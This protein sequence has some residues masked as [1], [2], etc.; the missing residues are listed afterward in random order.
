MR[1][2][3][4]EKIQRL[5]DYC[6]AFNKTF[7][8]TKRSVKDI[9]NKDLVE[10]VLYLSASDGIIQQDESDFINNLIGINGTPEKWK[11]YLEENEIYGEKFRNVVPKSLKIFVTVDNIIFE[12]KNNKFNFCT[13]FI[14][15]FEDI[16]QDII[17][18]DRKIDVIELRDLNKYLNM[19]KLYVMS[20]TKRDNLNYEIIAD[21]EEIRGKY[22]EKRLKNEV[23]EAVDTY[24]EI[25]LN[26][27]DD[28]SI[29]K[30]WA[31]WTDN[32]YRVLGISVSS[33]TEEA[34][35]SLDK[36]KKLVRL[37]AVES[38][39]SDYHLIGLNKP[40]RNLSIVQN[41]FSSLSDKKYKWFWFVNV[42]ACMAW[43]NERF[44]SELN[45][46]GFK[47]GS[48]DLF[49]A[50]YLYAV[51]FNP[52]MSDASLWKTVF[53]YCAFLCNESDHSMLKSRF[54][55][56][57]LKDIRGQDIVRSFKSE[58][59]KPIEV[60]CDTCD[61]LRIVRLYKILKEVKCIDLEMFISKVLS[62]L[63]RYFISREATIN[64]LVNDC[65]EDDVITKS[66]VEKIKIAGKKYLKEVEGIIGYVLKE[67]QDEPIRRDM[68]EE[69]FRHATWSL[70]FAFHKADERDTAVFYANKCYPH[71]REEDKRKIRWTFGFSSI[72]GAEKEASSAEWDNMGDNYYRGEDGYSQNYAEAFKWYKKAAEAGNKYSMNSLG[73]C[74]LNGNGTQK[75]EYEA[76]KWFEKAYKVG[77][78]YGAFN[79][80]NCYA[81]GEGK[82]EDKDRAI[83]LFLEA[84][85]MGHPTAAE[86]ADA[87]IKLVNLEKKNHR[88]SQ[89][90]H[91]DIGYQL[92][93]IKTII[94]E[95]TLN[96]SANVY[97]MEE[98]DYEKYCNCESFSYYGGRATQ[99]PYRVK[100]PK[101]GHWH[102]VIDNGDDDMTGIITSVKTRA[103]NF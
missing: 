81:N 88:L 38:F 36:I 7:P 13:L 29:K 97:L 55:D 61:I 78:S 92:P 43:Q 51:I 3:I 101:A 48:Y 41:A 89:H 47:Y 65:D 30:A 21:E 68:I 67:M 45:S 35:R 5:R 60:L 37:N 95:V 86:C 9:L 56:L 39:R 90:D 22:K 20:E 62:M 40:E 94:V 70:M 44:R 77:Y 34:N 52:S 33:T 82:I 4:K 71:C 102:L 98:E 100:I 54:N 24:E 15:I 58:I 18:A 93:I 31:F 53:A 14:S 50:N 63:T 10:F 8:S 76:A 49:L 91:Y 96:Y 103:F 73:L 2:D 64:K 32:P 11:K 17:Y 87:L 28:L 23:E 80:A 57:E 59:V 75:N 74:Y 16:G 42:D 85:K 19:L 84:A 46:D 27:N 99:S 12:K 6:E 26:T 69:S 83:E 25:D 66:E 1:S 72:E 79:L